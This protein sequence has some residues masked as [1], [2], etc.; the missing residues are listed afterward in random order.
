MKLKLARA[1]LHYTFLREKKNLKK[2]SAD[3]ERKKMSSK[4]NMLIVAN[5]NK[6]ETR[7]QNIAFS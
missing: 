2:C 3:K 7:N 4:K 6:K 1:L 5:D